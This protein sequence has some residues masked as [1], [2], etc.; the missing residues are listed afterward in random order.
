MNFDTIDG[1][2]NFEIIKMIGQGAVGTVYKV[3]E[4]MT[5]NIY[6]MKTVKKQFV[7]SKN[8][9]ERCFNEQQILLL[10]DHPFIINMYFTFQ[11][12]THLYFILDYCSGGNLYN[13]LKIHGHFSEDWIRFYS[14]EILLG[15]EYLHFMGC[16]YRDLKPENILI[17][18]CGHIAITD[19]DLAT[20]DPNQDSKINISL[21]E[22]IKN[23]FLLNETHHFSSEPNILRYSFVGTIEYI[24]PEILLLHQYTSGVDWWSFGILLFE[25][26]YGKTPFVNN[27]YNKITKSILNQ[28]P[29]FQHISKKLKSL[30]KKLLKKDP[31]KRLG[32]KGGANDIK[33]HI[34]YKNINW[35]FIRNNTPPYIPPNSDN[36]NNYDNNKDISIDLK[37]SFMPSKYRSRFNTNPPI[38]NSDLEINNFR[39]RFYSEPNDKFKDFGVLTK[40]QHHY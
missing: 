25:L 33:D 29:K 5:Q 17:K 38:Q 16:I 7:L 22:K 2:E 28:K 31:K 32:Y 20:F 30:I 35:Q 11:T 39:E 21:W 36:D 37:K 3:K 1:P 8:K 9:V 24:A 10:L 18:S 19:F 14:S 27:N 15:I 34:F 23:K 6:A 26:A 40:I 12:N 4:K 13:L